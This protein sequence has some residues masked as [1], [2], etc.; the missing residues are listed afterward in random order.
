MKI[1]I[2][3]IIALA[4]AYIDI[5]LLQNEEQ[6]GDNDK[7]HF[8]RDEI[9]NHLMATAVDLNKIL[10]N[11]GYN[12]SLPIKKN[13]LKIK[14][15]MSKIL[16]AT[17]IYYKKK[18]CWERW[19]AN[20]NKIEGSFDIL[21][22]DNSP[23]GSRL[24]VSGFQSSLKVLFMDPLP[25]PRE[26]LAQ[27]QN[28]ILDY[29]KRN[30]YDYIFFL[31]QDLFPEKDVIEHLLSFGVSVVGN[32][33]YKYSPLHD[34]D[35]LIWLDLQKMP[36]GS[37]DARVLPFVES[38]HQIDGTLKKVFNIGVGCCMIDI[39]VFDLIHKFRVEPDDE[40]HSDTYFAQDL[41]IS[42]IPFYADT[43]RIVK[44]LDTE[45]SLKTKQA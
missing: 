29:A 15:K 42:G 40:N 17:P 28:L 36:D 26:T 32:P 19:K 30:N 20:V 13:S 27:S 31:E 45:F 14:K 2:K 35:Y 8:T 10:E 4:I 12:V 21:L 7:I 37:L 22:V 16:L 38:F 3:S 44:H 11:E 23:K 25:N 18:Y 41:F 6:T 9:R 43:S 33:Y 24:D 34:T 39:K 5:K 1:S